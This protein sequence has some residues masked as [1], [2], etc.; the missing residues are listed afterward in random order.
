[1]FLLIT[2][3]LKECFKIAPFAEV[4]RVN[5]GGFFSNDFLPW[6][7]LKFIVENQLF[8]KEPLTLNKK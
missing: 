5:C 2:P 6:R 8:T 1:V 3:G 7:V 4:N